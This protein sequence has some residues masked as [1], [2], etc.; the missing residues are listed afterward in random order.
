MEAKSKKWWENQT[1]PLSIGDEFA[2]VGQRENMHKRPCLGNRG[3][4]PKDESEIRFF[5]LCKVVGISEDGIEFEWK[6]ET[7]K[8]DGWEI[9]W[10]SQCDSASWNEIMKFMDKGYLW[11]VK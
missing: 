8:D 2:V 4:N 6:Q 3:M 7:H 10:R 9:F 5:M 11:K 1:Q